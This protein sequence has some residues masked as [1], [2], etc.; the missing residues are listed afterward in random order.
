MHLKTFFFKITGV[1][2]GLIYLPAIVSV[3]YYFSTKRAFATGI[4]VCGSGMGAFVFAPLTQF[5][6]ETYDW[7]GA[8]L[9]IAGMALNCAVFGALMRPLEATPLSSKQVRESGK[10]YY[11]R[12]YLV[13]VSPLST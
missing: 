3:G 7:K 9:I 13:Y 1:G 10:S 4:A 12:H 5:L 8:L 11:S 2:F 6:L